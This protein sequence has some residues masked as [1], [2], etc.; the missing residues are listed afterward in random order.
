MKLKHYFIAA[1]VAFSL[2][3]A[4]AEPQPLGGFKIEKGKMIPVGQKGFK[5]EGDDVKVNESDITLDGLTHSLVIPGSENINCEKGMTVFIKCRWRTMPDNNEVNKDLDA[6]AHKED[7]FIF[8]RQGDRIYINLHDGKDWK[9]TLYSGHILPKSDGAEFHNLV[10]TVK[11]HLVID[12]GEDWIEVTA[13]LNGKQVMNRKVP[14]YRINISKK[15]IELASGKKFSKPWSFGGDVAEVQ[16]YPYVLG[17]AAIRKLSAY[18]K[19]H[20][21][22]PKGSKITMKGRNS[23]L[24]LLN[25]KDFVH[26][27]S[28]FDN[29]AKRD[30]FANGSRLFSVDTRKNTIA[31]KVS[32]LSPEMKS[33]LIKKPVLKNGVWSFSIAYSKESSAKS[34]VAFKAVCDFTYSADRLEYTLRI[35][36]TKN[37]R[38]SHVNYPDV[39]FNS[40]K[41]G[42]DYMLV[43]QM[44]GIAYPNAAKRNASFGEIYPRGMAS[45]QCGAFYDSKGGIYVSPGD[46]EGMIKII[47]YSAAENGLD[48]NTIY[49]VYNNKFQNKARAAVEIFR[50]DWYDAGLIYR[51]EQQRNK[52]KWWRKSLPNTDTPEWMRNATWCINIIFPYLSENAIIRLAEYFESA[53]SVFVWGWWEE[54]GT[55]LGPNIRTNPEILE[56]YRALQKHGIRITPYINGR[57]WPDRDRQ[58]ENFEYTKYGIPAAIINNGK[59]A[60][61][62][63]SSVKC[64]ILC[65]STKTYKDKISALALKIMAHGADGVYVDQ[66]GAAAAP[67]CTSNKHGHEPG[68]LRSWYTNGHYNTYNYIR[69]HPTAKGKILSTEDHTETC[70]GIFDTMLPWRW[71]YNDMVPLFPMVFSGRTQ[72]YGRDSAA[73][74]APFTKT[75]MMLNY[76]EQL[77]WYNHIMLSP[78]C[79]EIR[80]FVKRAIHSRI[81]MLPFFNEGMMARPPQMLTAVPQAKEYWGNHGDKFVTMPRIQTSLWQKGDDYALIIVNTSDKKLAGSMKIALPKEKYHGLV[82]PSFA[83]TEE[84][85]VRSNIYKYDIPAYGSQIV[86]FYPAGKCDA[87]LKKGFDASFKII[88]NTMTEKDPFSLDLVSRP[89]KGKVMDPYKWNDS[90]KSYFINGAQ[91]QPGGGLFWIANGTIGAGKYDFGSACKGFEIELVRM[92]SFISPGR[93]RFCINGIDEKDTVAEIAVNN[94]TLY[95]KNSKDWKTI[96]IKTKRPVSG[97]QNLFILFE[98][99]SFCN[100]KNWR[101]VK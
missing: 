64:V 81:A 44:C 48:A 70:V 97:K 29:I 78:L 73:I 34:P 90:G 92:K 67:I 79:G 41:N 89:Y 31:A 28:F 55:S 20:F 85:A 95:S 49:E 36:D 75:A 54:G 9:S 93:I 8:S 13:W 58:G 80:R 15:P 52:S 94:D 19:V 17:P 21:N 84:Y 23:S 42:T 56:Y 10:M 53:P 91:K 38:I 26:P 30:V 87:A 16:V 46:P 12:Q 50:G 74:N 4:A 32:P 66:V 71:F 14:N 33:T 39:Q 2:H 83:K 69:N 76:G 96:K 63:Y 18:K 68:D 11:H 100:A 5:S 77:G 65:P 72:F 35:S 6:F 40:L 24:V 82:Y 59:T 43:P 45:M 1:A 3:S 51:A 47:N 101:A 88:R 22:Y 99:Y 7:Q 61:E 57:L 37:G 98:G 25:A 27:V 60:T 86:Y 62:N